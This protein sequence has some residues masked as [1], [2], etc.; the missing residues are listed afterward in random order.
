MAESYKLYIE[1]FSEFFY[2]AHNKT[3]NELSKKGLQ[4]TEEGMHI[5]IKI[6]A[7]KTEVGILKVPR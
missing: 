3:T 4:D 1:L 2:W 7:E 5:M 6:G